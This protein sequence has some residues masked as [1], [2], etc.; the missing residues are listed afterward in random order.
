MIFDEI[1][2]GIKVSS[3]SNW[4]EFGEKSNKFFLNLDKRR[5]CQNTLR[6][7]ISKMENLL[8]YSK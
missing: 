5:G 7:I 8:N 6:N 3:R 4:Y 1:G 2:N